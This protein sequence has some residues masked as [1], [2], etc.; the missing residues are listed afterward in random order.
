M[1]ARDAQQAQ[2]AGKGFAMLGGAIG[3]GIGGAMNSDVTGKTKG[4]SALD[5]MLAGMTGNPED[6]SKLRAGGKMSDAIYKYFDAQSDPEKG[7]INPLG[8]KD[9]WSTM[10]A[11]DKLST[12]QGFIQGQAIKQVEQTLLQK[13]ME[14]Q[15]EQE[16]F[17]LKKQE[18]EQSL[19]ERAMGLQEG[20][21]RIKSRE[22]YVPFME[23]YFGGMNP[24]V[25]YRE[26]SPM[27]SAMQAAKQYPAGAR[28]SGILDQFVNAGKG[29]PEMADIGGNS[30]IFN[31]KTGQF[32]VLKSKNSEGT[33]AQEIFLKDGRPTGKGLLGDKVIDLSPPNMDGKD[34]S[35]GEVSRLA[36]LKQAEK[37]LDALE[38]LYVER[39][40]DYGGPFSGRARK[41]LG[42]PAI[43]GSNEG[44]VS[45][46][47][48]ITAAV[49]NL[50]RGVFREVGVLTKEDEARYKSLLPGPYD[51]DAVRKVK[52]DQLR[53]RLKDGMG[54]TMKTLKSAGRDVTGFE[55]PRAEAK[56]QRFE[57]EAAALAA[58][59][60][61]GDIVELYDPATAK[62]R[63]ARLK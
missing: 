51:S 48:A 39:G 18:A 34:L 21:E 14:T 43:L 31:R 61:I 29:A 24:Q 38:K 3:G 12:V 16:M 53:A 44:V 36:S 37:D 28:A 62:Y 40:A 45:L 46:E 2:N 57:N 15:Q 17:P 8:N 9:Q 22:E 32:D 25:P 11:K 41:I 30:V 47:N 59:K 4:K 55:Q 13:A 1:L 42:A 27:E 63:K 35:E 23:K 58:G 5:G 19:L 60:E 49:P 52:M 20:Q 33:V 54:E 6:Y 10:G 50:A 7:M 26:L 56:V